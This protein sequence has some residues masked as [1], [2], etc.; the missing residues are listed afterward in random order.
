MDVFGIG[1]DTLLLCYCIE[2]DVLR[3]LSYA[4]PEVLKQ[5]L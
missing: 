5:A 2:M 4:C 3:G 1:A